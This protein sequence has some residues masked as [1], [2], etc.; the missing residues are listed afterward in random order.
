MNL[1]QILEQLAKFLV[2]SKKET[3]ASGKKPRVIETITEDKNKHKLKVYE[4]ED[5]DLKY[6]DI[7]STNFNEFSGR[8]EVFYKGVL[9]WDMAY[10]GR[11][12]NRA[13]LESDVIYRFLKRA[14][15]KVDEKIPVRGPLIYNEV[16][17]G[18]ELQSH[19]EFDLTD[20]NVS[21]Y[22]HNLLFEPKKIVYVTHCLGGLTKQKSEDNPKGEIVLYNMVSSEETCLE[23]NT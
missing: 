3:Y 8:E 15:L 18:Y 21:E 9:I 14:L 17:L 11:I 22:I 4:F 6:I 23:S 19:G 7:F 2:K 10:I 1:E 12:I 5:G 20:F 16:N 13:K